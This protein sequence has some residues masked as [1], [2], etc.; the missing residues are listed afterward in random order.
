MLTPGAYADGVPLTKGD[1][2]AATG[3]GVVKHFDANGNLLDTLDTT[4]GSTFTTGM[5][6]AN[7]GNLYVTTFSG[8]TTS[9]FDKNGNLVA[10]NFGSG[11]N[12]DDESCSTDQ[13]GNIYVGQADG[14][15]QILKFDPSGNLLASYSPAT[16]DRGTDWIDLASDQCTMQYTSEG[17]SIK[18]FD[19]CTNTQLPDFA[20]GLP[21]GA[22]YAHRLLT[23]GTVL[24]ACTSEVVHLDKSGNVIQT[25]PEP[26][27]GSGTLFAL[28]IDP[29]GTSFWT[30]GLETG[31]VWKIDIASGAELLHF[32]S[33]S[34]GSTTNTALGGLSVVGEITAG[35]DPAITASGSPVS[36]T[37]GQPFS[38][39]VATVTDPDTSA[40]ASEYSA[41]I[42]WGDGSSSAGTI[43][44]TAGNFTVSGDHTY[45]EEGSYTVTTT[46]TDVDNTSNT[47]TATST[48]T[49]AD[50][51]LTAAGAAVTGVEGASASNTVATFTDANAGAPVS[52]FTVTIDW[53]D[54]TTSAG[55]VS[56]SGGKFTV[57]GTHAYAEEG[58]YTVKV[59]IKDDGGS[60]AAA[61]DTA[62]VSDAPLTATASAIHPVEGASGSFTAAT[63]TDADPG[64]KVSDYTATINWGDGA[65]TAGTIA[66]SGK[67]FSVSGPHT[68]AEEGT[69]KVTVTIKDA[70]GA[71]TSTTSTVKVAD[72][73]LHGSSTRRV[74]R[75]SF[76]GTIARFTDSDPRGKLSDYTATINWGDGKKTAGAISRGATFKVGGSHR[77]PK[78]GVYDIT[79]RIKDVGGSRAIVHSRVVIVSPG[80]A[81]LSTPTAC[82][83]SSFAAELRGKQIAGVTYAFDGRGVRVT[84]VHGG[85]LYRAVITVPPGLHRL[86]VKVTFRTASHT[87]S[88]TINRTITGCPPVPNFTG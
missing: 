22:C 14:S 64:G 3:S 20:T 2:L 6:F 26:T 87:K 21:G 51:A 10:A 74:L 68:Y 31:D 1:V 56:G 53:G 48:A 43:S 16:E 5:C 55:T 79:V 59:S 35:S 4:T 88:R 83:A 76:S 77:F 7:G 73:R 78:P 65:T 37:E 24:V 47:A 63:F 27:D 67:A 45:A 49:V 58:T 23:D 15:A 8:N 13:A 69:Y 80:S 46:I 11:Y 39:T 28:N 60:T 18:Q 50:A 57:S 86:S 66:A 54:G 38:G 17:S 33:F 44:G 41:T 62:K 72:A 19:V 12:S 81:A 52:D 70:G 9:V 71:T 61:T 32:N 85:T 75:G 42:N 30:G 29:D 40:T 84:T 34:A 82:V 36:A 25:Y